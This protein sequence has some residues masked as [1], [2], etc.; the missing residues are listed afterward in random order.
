MVVMTIRYKS[1][2]IFLFLLISFFLVNCKKKEIPGP[3]GDP[4]VAGTGGN[5]NTSSG[6]VFP[7][8]ASQWLKD[9]LAWSYTFNSDLITKAVAEKG[10]VKV[11]V[12][13]SGTWWELPLAEGDLLTQC[14]F[15]EGMVKLVYADIHGG[16]PALP[17]VTRNYR[18]VTLSE[19]A[20]PG[21]VGLTNAVPAGETVKPI[22]K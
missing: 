15:A 2:G 10:A 13:L 9:S 5:S 19:A 12:D 11:F 8:A 6:S 21:R 16:R 18:I 1:P 20:R 22:L 14:G 4:G 3:Q 7:I 17:P